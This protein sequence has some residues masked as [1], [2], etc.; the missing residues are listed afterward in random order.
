MSRSS[1]HVT[2]ELT[3][4]EVSMLGLPVDLNVV[5]GYLG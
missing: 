2:E 3:P 4:M 5:K 1:V